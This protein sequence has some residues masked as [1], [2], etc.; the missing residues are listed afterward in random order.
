MCFATAPELEDPRPVLLHR[1]PDAHR[2]RHVPAKDEVSQVE[3]ASRVRAAQVHPLQALTPLAIL[4]LHPARPSLEH[5]HLPPILD[6]PVGKLVAGAA[7]GRAVALAARAL[8]AACAARRVCTALARAALRRA[9][10]SQPVRARA[11]EAAF[12]VVTARAF[13]ARRPVP[14]APRRIPAPIQRA[15]V[16]VL[17]RLHPVAR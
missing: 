2:E 4:Q 6:H 14:A 17:A 3:P 15:L 8:L 1:H 9:I 10:V 11:S 13:P 16:H 12:G 7:L 5:R